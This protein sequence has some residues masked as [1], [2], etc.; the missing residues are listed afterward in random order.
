MT[1][2]RANLRLLIADDHLVVR[3]GLAQMIGT[4][5]GFEIVAEAENGEEALFLCQK[6]QPD[7]VLMDIRMGGMGGIAATQAI[8]RYHP[9]VRII[10]L[11]TFD[12]PQTMDQA[13]AAGASG[14]LSKTVTAN[15]LMDA[16]VRVHRGE[17]VI[18]AEASSVTTKP[19]AQEVPSPVLSAQQRKVLALLSKGCTNAEIA[20]LVNITLPTA[21]YHVSAILTKL[22]V[23]NRAEAVAVAI[24]DKLI[25]P[26][27]F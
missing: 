17:T 7:I 27:D 23:T 22:N 3:M 18:C 20:G 24:R 8:R 14:F 2:P 6:H 9:G 10:G 19:P 15:A 21:R 4:H 16:L 25:A 1:S 26:G 13:L 11:S 12:D 5:Q